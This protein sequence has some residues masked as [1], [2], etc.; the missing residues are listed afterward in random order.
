MTFNEIHEHLYRQHKVV[1]F[2]SLTSTKTHSVYCTINKRIQSTSD[3]I[4]VWDI[5]ADAYMDIEV[6]S[7]LTVKDLV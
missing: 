6:S 7:V 5:R 1:E 3:K 2:K 4:V